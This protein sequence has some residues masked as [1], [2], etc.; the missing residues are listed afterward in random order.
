[1]RRKTNYNIS[2]FICPCCGNNLPLPRPK[3]RRRTKGHIK[4]LYCVFCDKVVKT[5]EVRNG[6][7]YVSNGKVIY[8]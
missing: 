6:D 8:G 1:L 7:C 5:T 4:H 3:N 2:Y